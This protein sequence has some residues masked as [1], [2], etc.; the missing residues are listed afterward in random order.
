MALKQ[1]KKR[2]EPGP[3]SAFNMLDPEGDSLLLPALD[4]L[5]EYWFNIHAG[6]IVSRSV[7]T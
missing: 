4:L 3:V 6:S 1:G 2:G 5:H 7:L